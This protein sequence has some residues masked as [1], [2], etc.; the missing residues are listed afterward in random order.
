M[1]H[2]RS[3]TT[4]PRISASEFI[5]ENVRRHGQHVSEYDVSDAWEY[6]PE[7]RVIWKHKYVM[8]PIN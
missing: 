5:V 3:R 2:N 7:L 4:L 1:D 6:N 8:S